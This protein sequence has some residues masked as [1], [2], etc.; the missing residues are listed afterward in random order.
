MLKAGGEVKRVEETISILCSA[1]GAKDSDVFTITSSIV[2]TVRFSDK[3]SMTQTRRISG[4][5]NDMKR[6]EVLNDLSRRICGNLMSNEE[7]LAELNS[8]PQ[9]KDGLKFSSFVWAFVSAS[10]TMFFG[11]SAEDAVCSFFVG[12][13]LLVIHNLMTSR[14]VNRYCVIMLCSVIGGI[15][16]AIP[17][18]FIETVSPFYINIGNIM[19]LIPGVTLTTAIRDMF[20]G[21]TI[22]GLLRFFEAMLKSLVIAWGFAVF[23]VGHIIS[24]GRQLVLVEIIT[25]LIG[26][27]GFALI[28]NCRLKSGIIG[29]L[30]GMG[31]WIVVCIAKYFGL[32]EYI[33]FFFAAMFI[34]LFAALMA[35]VIRCPSTV[36]LLVGAIPLVPGKALYLTM[37]YALEKNWQDFVNQGIATVIFGVSISAGMILISLLLNNKKKISK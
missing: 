30:G 26:S 25:A 12:V 23:D 3:K 24:D 35:R 2:V 15:L 18:I 36:F 20:S 32:S 33:A 37:R 14:S 22:S 11:G 10:F 27:F 9:V 29:A 34:T 13:I 21:D 1:Y 31:G 5:R 16:A 6:L 17:G 7:I 8:L 4:Q 28:F 19:L